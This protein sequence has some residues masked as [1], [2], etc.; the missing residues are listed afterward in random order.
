MKPSAKHLLSSSGIALAAVLFVAVNMLAGMLLSPY[1]IDLT[2]NALFTLSKG[3]KH[4]LKN[5]DE[6]VHLRFF[7]SSETAT[8][9]TMI[10]A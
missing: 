6:P 2:E 8:G 9:F 10:Q 4:I 1:R 7:Y 3:T 5:L